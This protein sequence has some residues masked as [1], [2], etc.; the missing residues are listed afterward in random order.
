LVLHLKFQRAGRAS[1]VITDGR[2]VFLNNPIAPPAPQGEPPTNERYTGGTLIDELRAKRTAIARPGCYGLL[3]G[4]PWLLFYCPSAPHQSYRLYSIP[5]RKWRAVAIPLGHNPVAVGTYWIQYFVVD[6]DDYAFQNIKTGTM[7]TLDAWR[8]GGKTIPALDLTT[9]GRR[10]CSP[11][12]VPSDWTPYARWSTYPHYE[13]LHAG[14]V[15]LIGGFAIEQGTTRPHGDGV[16]TQ[17]QFI[18][19]CGS[20]LI[21]RI[22]GN[23][24]PLNS[25][26]SDFVANSGAVIAGGGDN[27]TLS[28]IALASLRPIAIPV[29]GTD[30]GLLRPY[31]IALSSRR[32]YLVDHDNDVWSAPSPKLPR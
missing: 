5:A 11:V 20:R 7:R 19:R 4:G 16:Y 17:E 29:P 24:A 30:R 23:E 1:S 26:R 31:D 10:L 15:T 27:S 3:A 12:R 2:Y 14:S 13:K 18:E 22:A 32:L 6:T 21:Q 25:T 9:L 28:G 8:P